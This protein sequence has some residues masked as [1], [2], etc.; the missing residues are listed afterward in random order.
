MNGRDGK[1]K[2]GENW[3]REVK[4]P[5]AGDSPKGCKFF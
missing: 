1:K 3:N 2:S 4:G 5:G